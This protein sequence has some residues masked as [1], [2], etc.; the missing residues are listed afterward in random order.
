MPRAPCMV[1]SGADSVPAALSSP[2]GATKTVV[3]SPATDA[4]GQ[5]GGCGACGGGSTNGWP[6]KPSSSRASCSSLDLEEDSCC[7]VGAYAQ[8]RRRHAQSN[9][10]S[11]AFGRD[12][13]MSCRRCSADRSTPSPPWPVASARAITRTRATTCCILMVFITLSEVPSCSIRIHSRNHIRNIKLY[14]S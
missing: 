8:A 12:E 13:A 3:G 5:D 7:S 9:C 14:Q 2:S 4:D 11:A 1:R 6:H 10:G